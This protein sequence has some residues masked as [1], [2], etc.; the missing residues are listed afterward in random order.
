MVIQRPLNTSSWTDRALCCS[1]GRRAPKVNC[2]MRK[3]DSGSL[4]FERDPASRD[5]LLVLSTIMSD[6]R[7]FLVGPP[8]WLQT[9]TRCLLGSPLVL[10][11]R[12]WSDQFIN[13]QNGTMARRQRRHITPG[14]SATAKYPL[15]V[16]PGSG[17]PNPVSLE[18]RK[19]KLRW[20][21]GTASGICT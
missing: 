18:S 3:G 6:S 14:N 7:D 19:K 2:T 12:K 11:A 15:L 8:P 21:G 16:Y 1:K 17:S 10:R 9:S 20:D 13:T 5:K 4:F